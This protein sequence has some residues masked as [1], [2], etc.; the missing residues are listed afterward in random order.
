MWKPERLP[1][2]LPNF[3][4]GWFLLPMAL[5]WLWWNLYSDLEN[6][7]II[8]IS[9]PFLSEW[10][11]DIYNACKKNWCKNMHGCRAGVGGGGGGIHFHTHTV[12]RTMSE[13]HKHPPTPTPIHTNRCGKEKLQATIIEVC[14]ESKLERMH[15]VWIQ[16]VSLVL[17]K[18][19]SLVMDL[20]LFS[21]IWCQVGFSSES[22]MCICKRNTSY[23]HFR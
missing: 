18:D 23:F 11:K 19:G 12:R 9:V 20:L 17:D 1:C 5:V 13:A 4:A 21:H 8:I 6:N 15:P 14:L 7:C 2:G 16:S 10:M 22:S 3:L